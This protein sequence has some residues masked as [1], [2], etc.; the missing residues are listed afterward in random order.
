MRIV[1]L[2]PPGAGKGTQAKRLAERYG[3]PIIGT[4]DIFRDHVARRTPLGLQAKAYMDRGDYVP[5]EIAVN[6]VLG[7]LQEP[8]CRVGFILDGFPRTVPQA[9]ALERALTEAGTPLDAVLNFKVSDEMVVKRLTNRLVCSSCGRPYNLAFKPPRIEGV[10][11]VCGA[12]LT[13]RSDDD[14]ATI[15]RRLDVYRRET[16][17]LVLYFWERGLLRDIDGEAPEQVVFD[18]TIEALSDL[19]DVDG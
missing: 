9:Q 8:D 13:L 10:C 19:L 2:G 1:L 5:D 12:P 15:L 17:P 3:L 4:G 14:E 11:D 16:E 18:R 7:R 6:M